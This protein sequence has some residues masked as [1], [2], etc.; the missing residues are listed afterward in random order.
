MCG[1]CGIL[2]NGSYNHL[3]EEIV[4]MNTSLR[5]RGPDDEG[6]LISNGMEIMALGGLDTPANVRTSYSLQSVNDYGKNA[7]WAFAHRRLAVLDI[8]EAGHQPMTLHHNQT[9]IVFNGEIYNHIVLRNELTKLGYQFRSSSDTEVILNAY[10]EWGTQ[11]VHKFN[12]MWS[13]VIYD[14]AQQIWFGSRDRL[15]VKPLY[16]YRNGN[17]FAFASEQKALHGCRM[18][19]T[20]INKQTTFNYLVLSHSQCGSFFE[21]IEELPAGSSFIFNLPS[22]QLTIMDYYQNE[23]RKKIGIKSYDEA[24]RLVYEQIKKTVSLR[25]VADVEVGS[26]LS[27]GI[28]ST[29]IVKLAESILNQSPTQTPLKVF[30]AIYPGSKIDEHKWIK[31][32]VKDSNLV[33]YYTQ[34]TGN[35]LVCDIYDMLYY[36]DSPML[37]TS[38][39]SQYRVMKL[40]NENRVKVLLDGQ[41]ADELFAGYEVCNWVYWNQLLKTYKIS[42][43]FNEINHASNPASSTKEWIRQN[44]KY[45]AR[46]LPAKIIQ[47]LSEITVWENRYIQNDFKNSSITLYKKTSFP[48]GSDLNQFLKAYTHGEKL[49]AM[50]RLEDRMSM[51]FSIE[52]RTPFADDPDL[53][54][55]AQSIPAE[56]KIK[57]GIRKKVLR[58]AFNTTIP[59]PI[60]NRRDKI[61]FETPEQE[62]IKTLTPLLP[63]L[64]TD[65]IEEFV[66]V[67]QLKQDIT[68]FGHNPSSSK[69]SRILRYFYL[70]Q[71]RKAY[72]I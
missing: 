23:K 58:D 71:W 13:F 61:G 60:F 47:Q 15:G 67:K 39:Y 32:V 68:L 3:V 22:H 62:W 11:C 14:P 64:I 19:K 44:L 35:D 65:N 18:V 20:K 53:I 21:G 63:E 6:Y 46:H 30:S 51:R 66:N 40:A 28:D 45:A 57:S 31:E 17:T 27:G 37:S 41:G 33:P 43:L 12:G 16:Y 48:Y 59:T 69:M 5:H 8:S 56:Y 52:S 25:M 42:T 24:V 2:N 36:A 4:K 70:S 50:L 49:Q 34:P 26:C 10:L 38:T 7:A 54:H 72:N 55:L 29:I 1:I 9:S